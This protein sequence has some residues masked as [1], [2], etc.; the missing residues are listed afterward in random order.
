MIVD[1]LK[2][3]K[4]LIKNKTVFGQQ[5]VKLK[6]GNVEG[7]VMLNYQLETVEDE[8]VTSIDNYD[9]FYGSLLFDRSIYRP[10]CKQ[11]GN[12]SREV[13]CIHLY[14]S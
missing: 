6:L 12:K 3:S 7:S 1:R 11:M 4:N 2:G 13:N 5:M 9:E 14:Q 8:S 10:M